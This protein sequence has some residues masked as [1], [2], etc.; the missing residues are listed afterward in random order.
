MPVRIQKYD[1]YAGARELNHRTQH[2]LARVMIEGE[3]V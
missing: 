2:G 3:S 1:P